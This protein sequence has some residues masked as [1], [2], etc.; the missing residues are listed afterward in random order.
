MPPEEFVKNTTAFNDKKL[1]AIFAIALI[2]FA[3]IFYFFGVNGVAIKKDEVNKVVSYTKENIQIDNIDLAKSEGKDRIP[4]GFPQDMPIDTSTILESYK[5][6]YPDRGLVQYIVSYTSEKTAN[7]L[8]KE[9][10]D[11]MNKA[12]YIIFDTN[13]KDQFR[14]SLSGSKGSARLSVVIGTSAGKM[15]VTIAYSAIK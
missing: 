15:L 1:M 10:Q 14:S 9:Y 5:A 12:D 8:L 13:G 7:I 11:Y 3:G 6:T 2:A 4:V